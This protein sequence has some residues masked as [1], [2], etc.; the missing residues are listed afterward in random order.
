M[1]AETLLYMLIQSDSTLAPP[2]IVP[3]FPK[4]K[5][6]IGPATWIDMPSTELIVGM[7]DI[8]GQPSG[9][10][11][12]WDNEKPER[13]MQVS[14]FQIQSRPI[15]NGEY[16][17]FIRQAGGAPPKSWTQDCRVRTFFGSIPMAVAVNWPVAASYNEL[18]RYAKWIGARLPTYGELRTFYNQALEKQLATSGI[19]TNGHVTNG[20]A[21]NGH[22]TNGHATNG[23]LTN[24]SVIQNSFYDLHGHN[25]NFQTWLPAEL[26]EHPNPQ[27][28]SGGLIHTQ[29]TLES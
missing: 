26:K 17:K 11:F 13:K 19:V 16:A 12:G 18:A 20:H 23:H 21:I 3:A 8:E 28:Y 27:I 29:S 2:G 7:N 6:E 25:V 15:T 9:A 14:G 10:F 1:H 4:P 5:N 22:M 24:G